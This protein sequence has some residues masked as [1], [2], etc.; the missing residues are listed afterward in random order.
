METIHEEKLNGLTI[1]I[2]QDMNSQSPDDWGDDDLFL[3][4][5]DT[6]NFFVMPKDKKEWSIKDLLDHYLD[7]HHI[8]S[9]EAYIHSG[10]CLS[11]SGEGNFPDRAF[12]VS[13]G[14]GC[15]FV[16]KK[17]W[18]TKKS[19]KHTAENHV[20]TWNDYLSGNVYGYQVE[21]KDGN[22]IESCWGFYGDYDSKNGAL[23]EAR[24]IVKSIT[25]NGKTDSNGQYLF[26]FMKGE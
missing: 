24:N 1:K 8:F 7:T 9:L 25:N 16:S 6:R 4:G 13:D 22:E 20:K 5:F 23:S 17:Y 14:I 26:E 2:F 11:L 12:D 3:A 18:K 10:I 19:A 15:V 21:D